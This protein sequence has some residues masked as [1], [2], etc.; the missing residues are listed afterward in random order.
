MHPSDT[1]STSWGKA[2]EEICLD[3]ARRGGLF[4]NSARGIDWRRRSAVPVVLDTKTKS[5]E[6]ISELL[7]VDGV[8]YVSERLS[9]MY[10]GK[11]IGGR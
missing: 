10:T 4:N 8:S 3:V 11:T 5:I 6:P 1:I 9:T 2:I 7:V